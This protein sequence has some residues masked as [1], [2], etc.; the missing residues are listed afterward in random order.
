M[1]RA[2]NAAAPSQ[3]FDWLPCS[4][5]CGALPT[6]LVRPAVRQSRMIEG[7]L[8][9]ARLDRIRLRTGAVRRRRVVA[10][11]PQCQDLHFCVGGMKMGHD[12]DD[13]SGVKK[14]LG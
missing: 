1:G 3:F 11:S 5:G 10:C 2:A 9:L 14:W 13:A 6:H 8:G 12:S 4:R 7:W